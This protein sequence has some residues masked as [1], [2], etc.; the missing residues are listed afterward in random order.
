MGGN[1]VDTQGRGGYTEGYPGR[2]IIGSDT[3]GSIRGDVMTTEI[4]ASTA[5]ELNEQIVACNLNVRANFLKMAELLC[6]MRDE[7]LYIALDCPTFESY[8]GTLGVEG[9]RSWLYKLIRAWETFSK[10]LGVSDARLIEAGP[11]KLDIIAPVVTEDNK[12]EWLDKTSLSKSDLINEVR[13]CQGKPPLSSLK[14]PAGQISQKE[15][16]SQGIADLLSKYP[17]YLDYVRDQPCM[18]CSAPP[19]SDAHHFPQGRVRTDNLGKTVPLCRSCH[20][21]YHQSP[22]KFLNDYK[23]SWGDYFFSFIFR[24]WGAT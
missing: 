17:T 2:K 7:K 13:S 16:I 23:S 22:L 8:L 1:G 10:R 19:P 21:E 12:D 4:V 5:H 24:I 14:V 9:N 20:Q 3:K 11:S 15:H 18:I 6:R